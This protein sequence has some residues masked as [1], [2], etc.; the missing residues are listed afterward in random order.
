MTF[1][2][3]AMLERATSTAQAEAASLTRLVD[4]IRAERGR[5]ESGKRGAASCCA[6]DEADPPSSDDKATPATRKDQKFGSRSEHPS[7]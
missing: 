5:P 4:M 1:A 3:V 7:L 6:N 2:L